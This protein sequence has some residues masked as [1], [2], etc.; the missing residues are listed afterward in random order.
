[1]Y[2]V[3]MYIMLVVMLFM[4]FIKMKK[5]NV[6]WIVFLAILSFISTSI[7]YLFQA[8]TVFNVMNVFGI[9]IH[10]DD[11]ILIWFLLYAI[12]RFIRNRYKISKCGSVI[13]LILGPICF[14]LIRGVLAGCAG[15]PI[16]LIDIRKYFYFVVALVATY[17]AF[18]DN[19]SN[20]NIQR[21]YRDIDIFMNCVAVYVIVIWFLDIVL[22][23]NNLPGQIGGTLSDG[24]ST[25][26]IIQ[27]QHVLLIALYTSW[28]LYKNL[29]EYGVIKLRT[30]FFAMIV[31]L[32]QW[33]TVVIAFLVAA[34]LIFGVYTFSKKKYTKALFGEIALLILFC[35]VVITFGTGK[36]GAIISSIYSLFTSY[37]SVS[38]GSGT[39][40]T[41]VLVWNS[42]LATLS[43][44]N[45][46]FGRPFGMKLENSMSWTAAAH[47]GYVDYILPMGYV[48]LVLF[49]VFII[50]LLQ[51]LMKQKQ[52]VL[53]VVIVSFLV[54]WIGYGFSVHQGMILGVC[55]ATV[56]KLKRN[57]KYEKNN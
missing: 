55:M 40:G 36:D 11:I 48:G 42:L 26:R 46:F 4:T 49:I 13:L 30:V 37:N 1:M 2:T 22:G 51:S 3:F 18:S 23:I 5:R 8:T 39:F 27:P 6:E 9:Q 20:A 24:G 10:L 34:V 16:F 17:C 38:S 25:M 12:T 54:Y 14:S 35:V 53:S 19:K 47:S 7:M 52:V 41:R 32:M 50:Y 43:G 31:I 45:V 33:R 28:M 56:K 44:V 15:S 21:C 29:N 57:F